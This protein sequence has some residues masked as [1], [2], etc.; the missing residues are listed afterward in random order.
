[1]CQVCSKG[2]GQMVKGNRGLTSWRGVYLLQGNTVMGSSMRLLSTDLEPKQYYTII[3]F[4]PASSSAEF[5][6]SF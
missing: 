1:M 4:Q 3:H 6:G 5:Q 2:K